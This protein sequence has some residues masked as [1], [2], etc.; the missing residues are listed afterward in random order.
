MEE[1][2]SLIS[3]SKSTAALFRRSSG[4]VRRIATLFRLLELILVL[5]FLSWLSLRLPF[6][7]QISAHFLRG[8]GSVVVSPLFV[9]ALGNAIVITLV[10]KSGQLTNNNYSEPSNAS[11]SESVLASLG[12][13]SNSN[14][15]SA[16]E[17]VEEEVV[18]E[19][20]EMISREI[21]AVREDF[22]SEAVESRLLRSQ[23]ETLVVKKTMSPEIVAVEEE[24]RML[25][26]SETD[27]S[28]AAAAAK[29]ESESA[30][31]EEEMSSEEFR[32]I[33]EAFIA[34]QKRFRREELQAIVVSGQA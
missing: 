12:A 3:N 13:E 31:E 7:F 29:E 25:R 26:R 21:V 11:H 17:A 4:G 6:A 19:D 30:V 14:P 34:K 10:A 15:K 20:K 8:L 18:F 24:K 5:A 1:T 28:K 2:L 27:V 23:S 9:F 16:V 33:I 32:R 22:A